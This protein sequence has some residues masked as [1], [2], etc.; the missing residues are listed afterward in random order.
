MRQC[1]CIIILSAIV[2]SVGAQP[3]TI[4]L[5]GQWRFAMDPKDAG[6]SGQW[7]NQSLADKISLPGILQSQGYGDDISIDTPWVAA[8]PRNF[9]GIGFRNT[10]PTPRRAM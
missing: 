9:G 1:A 4:D 2:S 5:S 8:L 10:K 3:T 6:A 7:Y